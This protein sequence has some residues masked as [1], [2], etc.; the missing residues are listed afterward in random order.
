MD[1]GF[2]ILMLIFSAALLVYAGILAVTKNYNLLPT[3]A[4]ISVK[5]KNPKAYTVQLAKVIALAAVCIAAGAGIAFW[6]PLIGAIVMIA[7]VAVSCWAG[8]K[9]VKD[10]K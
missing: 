2:P 8:T 9:I 1:N 3:R 10:K 4:T 5:P 6:N 7:G